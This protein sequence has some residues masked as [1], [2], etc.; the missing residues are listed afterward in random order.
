MKWKTLLM[1]LLIGLLITLL[2]VIAGG[3][4]G[5]RVLTPDAAMGWDAIANMLGGMMIGA[6]CGVIISV[7]IVRARQ[8]KSKK[9][10]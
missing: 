10:Y 2:C 7:F 6:G 9:E 8:H 4:I 5:G 1:S 3:F